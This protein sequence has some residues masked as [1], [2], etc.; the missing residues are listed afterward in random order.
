MMFWLAIYFLDMK[1]YNRLLE[2]AVNAI[3]ELEQNK[4]AFLEKKEI[5]LST[6][7]EKAFTERFKH[8]N[9]SCW[10]KIKNGRNLFYLI[11]FIGLLIPCIICLIMMWR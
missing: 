4:N 8:E 1:Y 9:K 6:N 10:E 11:V 7:I 3:L 2:G 5:N